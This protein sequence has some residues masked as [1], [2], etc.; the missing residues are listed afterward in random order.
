MTVDDE[1]VS[2]T[3]TATDSASWLLEAS[4]ERLPGRHSRC[5]GRNSIHDEESGVKLTSPGCVEL[6]RES[7]I[8]TCLDS[9]FLY[10]HETM[11]SELLYTCFLL[12]FSLAKLVYRAEVIQD[13]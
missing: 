9:G 6:L 10:L 3:L 8:S 5:S 7:L 12:F 1:A 2:S 11:L 4:V 13:M